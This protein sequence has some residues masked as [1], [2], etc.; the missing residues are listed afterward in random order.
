MFSAG[1]LFMQTCLILKPIISVLFCGE[2]ALDQLVGR[3]GPACDSGAGMNINDTLNGLTMDVIGNAAFGCVGWR[4]GGRGGGLVGE[5][6]GGARRRDA[7][8]LWLWVTP[9]NR[10]QIPL[11]V[12]CTSRG[13]RAVLQGPLIA[14]FISLPCWQYLTLQGPRTRLPIVRTVCSLPCPLTEPFG[15][16]LNSAHACIML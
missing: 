3:L 15:G 1:V 11:V 4:E 10:W 8:Q 12:L 5:W 6:I 2:Q 16:G 7:A 9:R 13:H 14:Q